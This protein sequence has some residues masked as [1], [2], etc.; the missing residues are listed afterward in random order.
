MSFSSYESQQ[1]ARYPQRFR[2]EAVLTR[3][4]HELSFQL[5][6]AISTESFG[7]HLVKKTLRLIHSFNETVLFN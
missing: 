6:V 3:L 7:C 2:Q 5:L 1:R 4:I